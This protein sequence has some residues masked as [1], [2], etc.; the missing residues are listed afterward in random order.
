MRKKKSN[1]VNL[2]IIMIRIAGFYFIYFCGNIPQRKVKKFVKTHQY[3]SVFAI[4]EQTSLWSIM[5][6]DQKW[7]PSFCFLRKQLEGRWAEC[8][9]GGGALCVEMEF[10]ADIYWESKCNIEI[11][12]WPHFYKDFDNFWCT[13]LTLSQRDA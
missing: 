12:V 1:L 6:A 13:L 3:Y 8:L 2:K 5:K 11:N 9:E 7:P 10:Y 4:I